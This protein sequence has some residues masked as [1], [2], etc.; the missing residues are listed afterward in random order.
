MSNALVPLVQTDQ[1]AAQPATNARTTSRANADFVAHLIA[2][3]AQ[4]P[5]TRAR[6]RANSE[7]AIAAYDAL[8]HWTTPAGRK[9]SRSL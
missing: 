6:R 3:S 5:Q 2:T 7:D 9:L 4:A 8:G 1:A